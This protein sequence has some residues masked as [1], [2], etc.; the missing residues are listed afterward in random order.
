M[1]AQRASTVLV[2]TAVQ[3]EAAS[4]ARA[5]HARVHEFPL[6]RA[7]PLIEGVEI[8]R[9]G[10]GPAAAGAGTARCLDHTRHGALLSMGVAGA[11]WAGDDATS[12]SLE[13]GTSMLATR[14]EFTDLGLRTSTGFESVADMGFGTT[15]FG[16]VFAPDPLLRN[17]LAPEVDVLGPIATV[18]TCSGTDEL[19]RFVRDRLHAE[20]GGEG[21]EG[22]AVGLV[23][24]LT[25]PGVPFAEV[26]VISNTTG[27]RA[28]QTW[29]LPTAF[30]AL[31]RVSA[32][33]L[34]ALVRALQ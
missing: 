19:A 24:A 3:Q 6:W 32:C 34:P 15:E 11:T 20:P 7:I 26:R 17:A 28:R 13:I 23:A 8:V 31:E 30:G 2:A 27:D 18:S 14:S 1:C 5:L 4:I 9:I 33:V 10:V 12:G 16:D 29:D 25:G 22:A 21:M